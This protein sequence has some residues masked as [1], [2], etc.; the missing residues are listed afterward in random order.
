MRYLRGVKEVI[1]T[2]GLAK[3]DHDDDLAIL[4]NWVYYHDVLARFTLN[5]W[6]RETVAVALGQSNIRAEVSYANATA[7]V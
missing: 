6:H 4:L 1:E 3:M 5:H 2:A 7:P